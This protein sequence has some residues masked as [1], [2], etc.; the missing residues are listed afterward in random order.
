MKILF[1]IL[2]HIQNLFYP[3]KGE[4]QLNNSTI[5]GAKHIYVMPARI[6]GGHLLLKH[7]DETTSSE[8]TG[9]HRI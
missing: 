8:V 6:V 4:L 3:E 5:S 2:T 9:Q 7:T 1:G